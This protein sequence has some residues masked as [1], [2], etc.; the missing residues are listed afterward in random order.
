MTAL[1]PY[2]ID[3]KRA[4]YEA[5][6]RHRST[7]VCMPTGTGKT[8]VFASIIAD[9]VTAGRRVLVLAHREELLDQAAEKISAAAGLTAEIEQSTRKGTGSASVVVACV[10]SM[11]HRLHRYAPDH[12]DLIVVD[13]CHHVLAVSYRTVL[14]HFAPAKWVGFTA[15]PGRGD[16]RALGQLIENVAFDLSLPTAILDGWLVRDRT[17]RI[18]LETLD[19]SAVRRRSGDLAAGELGAA[20]SEVAVVRE[21]IGP[22]IEYAAHLQTI[23]F[24]VTVPH[25]YVLAEASI[26]MAEERGIDL[27]VAVVDGNTPP[28]RRREIMARF[29]NRRI[30]WLFNCM[31]ATEGF[32]APATECI[33]MLR[34]TESRALA[35]QMRGRG[36]RPLPGVV[37]GIATAE[38]RR[39]AI[40]AS[41]KREC[42]VLDF[43]ANTERFAF[44]TEMDLLGGD[45]ELP[46]QKEAERLLASGDAT[47]LLEALEYAR[48]ARQ[49]KMR[50]HLARA[51]DPFALFGLTAKRHRFGQPM[52]EAQAKVLGPMRIPRKM[53]HREA[54]E[55][56]AEL[57]RR[58]AADL[59][60]YS[61]AALLARL[62][63]PIGPLATMTRREAGAKIR[64]LA[65]NYWRP[66]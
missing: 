51:G 27:S 12:F 59:C 36:R 54:N 47:D 60:L 19:L 48:A 35:E 31:V 30:R 57:A 62:R 34:P 14:D 16:A 8:V 4:V 53:D 39:H 5:L 9:A 55:L 24:A 40:R 11:V 33:A 66:Q 7:L 10:F 15:T 43:T 45:Y 26:Q 50:E 21:A 41:A 2:Q 56:L 38:E 52:S 65:G 18:V 58:D 20:M 42:L 61:Q 13:E 37:D 22:M 17:V 6:A 46:E 32:D 3:A 49:S 63:F 28:D 64:D 25:A 23:A 44:V 1:R 29:R